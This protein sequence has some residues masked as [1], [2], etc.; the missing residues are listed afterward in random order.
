MWTVENSLMK[1]LAV[2]EVQTIYLKH[3]PHSLEE[4]SEAGDWALF[5]SLLL[6]DRVVHEVILLHGLVLQDQ[7]VS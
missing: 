3:F 4:F 6:L 2:H 5:G 1:D 7:L